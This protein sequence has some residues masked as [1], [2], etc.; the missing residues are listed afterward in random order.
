MFGVK[1]NIISIGG[2][3]NP[4]LRVAVRGTKGLGATTLRPFEALSKLL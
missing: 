4:P 3:A 2:V 1:P